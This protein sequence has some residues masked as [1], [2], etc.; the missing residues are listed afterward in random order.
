MLAYETP[1][2]ITFTISCLKIR[3]AFFLDHNHD[4]SEVQFFVS[5]SLFFC[6]AAS[7]SIG[8]VEIYC[9]F[10]ITRYIYIYI[11]RKRENRK[12]LLD[13]LQPSNMVHDFF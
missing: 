5:L 6:C 1:F 11:Y 9:L 2:I 10:N 12:S 8:V 13:G 4:S 3:E 7:A